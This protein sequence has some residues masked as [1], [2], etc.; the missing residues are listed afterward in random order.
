MIV[1]EEVNSA[2]T[3][4]I[5]LVSRSFSLFVVVADS[6]LLRWRSL[7]ASVVLFFS[8]QLTVLTMSAW[9]ADL[10]FEKKRHREKEVI[11]IFEAEISEVEDS[12]NRTKENG[13]AADGNL[14][15]AHCDSSQASLVHPRVD[16]C[17]C[18]VCPTGKGFTI[19]P[20]K[21][22]RHIAPIG[23]LHVKTFKKLRILRTLF[24]TMHKT[25]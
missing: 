3:S 18:P 16:F 20:K 17:L 22:H 14:I 2:L 10:F 8:S 9:P 23:W 5:Y 6:I 1:L 15:A 19:R 25:S 12:S 7:H 21:P 11:I 4:L 13:R 24:K